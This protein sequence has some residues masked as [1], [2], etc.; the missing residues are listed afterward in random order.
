MMSIR[1]RG[2]GTLTSLIQ[3]V[4]FVAAAASSNGWQTSGPGQQAAEQQ[5]AAIFNS[6]HHA[7][8]QW[9]SSLHHNGMSFYL[10]T[11]PQ[12]VLLHHGSFTAKTPSPQEP[13]WMAF[14]VEHAEMFAR[15]DFF[16]RPSREFGHD[17]QD[18]NHAKYDGF[19][20]VYRTTRPLK[21]LYLDGSAAGKTD[22]GT[23]DAQDYVLRGLDRQPF[24]LARSMSQPRLSLPWDESRRAMDLCNLSTTLGLDGMIRMEIGFEV[25]K[26]DFADGLAKVS[27]FQR[28]KEI[29]Y[30]ARPMIDF[31]RAAAER[32]DGIGAGRVSIDFSSMVSAF[33]YP[34]VNLTNPD[35]RRPDLPRLGPASN[36][37]E[38]LASIKD[39][40]V[41]M[42]KARLTA[43]A[44]DSHDGINW[45]G[46]SDMIVGRYADRLKYLSEGNIDTVERMLEH[47]YIL[48]GLYLNDGDN[49]DDKESTGVDRC[50]NFYI[51]SRLT[52]NMTPTDE[53]L[54]IAFERV[55]REICKT[56]FAIRDLLL[57]SSV[58]SALVVYSPTKRL[59][60][61]KELVRAL[62]KYL[63]W[64]RFKRCPACAIDEICL[65]PM[66]PVGT[67][68][69]Y[70]RP[71]CVN[72]ST[73]SFGLGNDSYWSHYQQPPGPAWAVYGDLS[74]D[75][76]PGE[77]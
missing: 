8:R 65:V 17:D 2:L 1:A 58:S 16:R 48:I 53:L 71:E 22:M 76:D 73:I 15:K 23:L 61:A 68:E 44:G 5:A 32:Y 60:S 36:K 72:G 38:R 13:D 50:T 10:A 45:Q 47:V 6:V 14:E 25:I 62:M 67:L 54:L 59:E 43:A 37:L 75:G 39:D 9:G 31:L 55:T 33:F 77:L 49:E 18:D 66:W 19:V 26:C 12:G 51:D 7:M 74:G 42:V 27:A 41:A 20:H 70:E 52:P 57:S 46:I 40:V 11:V 56:L 29:M 21:L 30:V 35:M 63:N 24:G 69:Q 34:D 3:L 28:A 4:V 64:T